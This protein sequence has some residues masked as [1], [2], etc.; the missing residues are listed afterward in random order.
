MTRLFKKAGNLVIIS[1]RHGRVRKTLILL[2]TNLLVLAG[3]IFTFEI[4]LIFLGVGDVVLP[5]PFLSG[6]FIKDF[7]F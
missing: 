5:F 6:D 4:V 7:V 2:F 3:L 1:R